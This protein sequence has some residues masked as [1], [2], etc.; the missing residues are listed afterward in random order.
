MEFKLY[1]CAHCG[2]VV[3]KVVDKGVPVICCGEL[4]SEWKPN[5][6]DGALEKHVPVVERKPHGSGSTVTVKVGE[7]AHPMLPE[8]YIT[9]IAAVDG[10]TV[11]LRF[12]KPGD[13]PELRTFTSS[14]KV[15]AYEIC[16]LHGF[17]KG[18]G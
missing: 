18:E 9:F 13:A 15:E 16:N 12:P 11:T 7:V 6:A 1:R 8:H 2:N 3:W 4:M 10:D 14:E 5:T 17:W